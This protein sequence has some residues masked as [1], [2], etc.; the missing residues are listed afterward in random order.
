MARNVATVLVSFVV[1]FL[2]FCSLDIFSK[3]IMFSFSTLLFL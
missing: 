1:L 2:F 3:F